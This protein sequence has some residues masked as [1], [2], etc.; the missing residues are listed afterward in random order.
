LQDTLGQINDLSQAGKWLMEHTENDPSARET[1]A[2]IG[3]WH[4]QRHAQLL[5]SLPLALR[6][7]EKQLEKLATHLKPH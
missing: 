2:L 7:L 3:N 4:V 6:R 5:A 1:V